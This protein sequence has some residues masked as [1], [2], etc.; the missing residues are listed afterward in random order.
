MYH[1]L[2]IVLSHIYMSQ[3]F[4]ISNNHIFVIKEAMHV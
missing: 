1:L 3:K 4:N 2:T